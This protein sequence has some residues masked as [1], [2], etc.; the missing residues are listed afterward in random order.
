MNE[1]SAFRTELSR[2]TFRT[3]A[4]IFIPGPKSPLVSHERTTSDYFNIYIYFAQNR[5]KN[6][7]KIHFPRN[8]PRGVMVNRSTLILSPGAETSVENNLSNP[9]QKTPEKGFPDQSR[10]K[11]QTG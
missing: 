3:E 2:S 5:S 8:L 4:H 11:A 1:F 6:Q 9:S 7:R 10:F